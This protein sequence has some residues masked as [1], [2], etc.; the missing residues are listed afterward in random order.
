MGGVGGEVRGGGH[1][2]INGGLR[3]EG[4]HKA[5]GDQVPQLRQD[6]VAAL[7]AGVEELLRLAVVRVQRQQ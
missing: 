1:L 2:P 4:R 3:Q 6:G 7:A 5:A